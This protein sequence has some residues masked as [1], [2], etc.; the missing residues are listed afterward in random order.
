MKSAVRCSGAVSVAS[1]RGVLALRLLVLD[2]GSRFQLQDL[3]DR[4]S[5]DAP[6]HLRW[7][8]GSS[9]IAASNQ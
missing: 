9:P 3:F 6:G 5:C 2:F 4:F 8:S 7:N 1:Q